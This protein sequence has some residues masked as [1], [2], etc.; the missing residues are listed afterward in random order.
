MSIVHCNPLILKWVREQ[1]GFNSKEEVAKKL[2][3]KKVIAQ[4]ITEWER[5]TASPSYSQLEDLAYKIY[6]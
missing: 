3:R 4:T 2:K 1:S 6:N 5:G